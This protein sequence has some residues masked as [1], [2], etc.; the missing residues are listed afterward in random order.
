MVIP[1][2]L[3][4]ALGGRKDRKSRAVRAL[5]EKGL[6][7]VVTSVM[8]LVIILPGPK[9]HAEEMRLIA[10]RFVASRFRR[11]VLQLKL[12]VPPRIGS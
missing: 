9:Q 7:L 4:R 1:I 10:W 11:Q 3:A 6:N 12:E 5:A 8:N 2:P